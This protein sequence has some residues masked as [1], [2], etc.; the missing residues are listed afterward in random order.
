MKTYYCRDENILL[1]EFSQT[2]RAWLTHTENSGQEM[3]MEYF[4]MD[5]DEREGPILKFELTPTQRYRL[6]SIWQEYESHIQF[7]AS[8]LKA[9]FLR[10]VQ[11]LD[12]AI[13]MREDEQLSR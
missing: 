3:S 7:E 5:H 2:L 6:Y 10:F 8:V 12:A 13:Q 1:L 11:V 4:T 9:I